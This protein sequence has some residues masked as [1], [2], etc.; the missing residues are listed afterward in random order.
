MLLNLIGSEG[1]IGKAIKKNA[2]DFNL[3]CWSHTSDRKENNF[4]LYNENSWSVLLSSSPKN[5]L[6][7]AW[8]GLPN[9][10][11]SF[12]LEKNLP[13]SIRLV[14]KLI[15]SGCENIIITGTCYEYGMKTGALRENMKIKPV[16]SYGLAKDSLRR[17]VQEMC[18]KNNVR[19][20]WSRIFY[21]YGRGQ[22]KNSLYPSLL[23]AIEENE[24]QF[25]MSSGKQIR[26]FINVDKV[27]MNLLFLC[28]KKNVSGIFN[29]GSGHP[30]SIAKFVEEIIKVKKS[31]ICL[32]KNFFSDREYEPD[33]FWA[34]M[35]KFN[36]LSYEN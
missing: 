21:P 1:F 9:Y 22:N 6:L 12:H 5:V 17:R 24:K 14:E 7:L 3:C 31:N 25:K 4:D 23:K 32:E 19:W 36:L 35:T 10:D 20:A 16:N 11:D 28:S 15:N 18:T 34:D 29:C 2:L 26:D 30:I 13:A 27:A 33:A 8:P